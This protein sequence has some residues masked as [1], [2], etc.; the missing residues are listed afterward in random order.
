[1]LEAIGYGVCSVFNAGRGGFRRFFSRPLHH[2]L[3]GDVWIAAAEAHQHVLS[4]RLGQSAAFLLDTAADSILQ[5]D[6]FAPAES[7]R[8]TT[9]P[10]SGAASPVQT[11]LKP[12]EARTA[13]TWPRKL[14]TRCSSP[15]RDA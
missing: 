6:I 5:L 7:R 4:H 1:M 3:Q 2:G 10:P 9:T 8:G 13:S 11:G 12:K 14:Q 15:A